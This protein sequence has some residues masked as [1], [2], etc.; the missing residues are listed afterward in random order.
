MMKE[1]RVKVWDIAVRIFHWS[2]VLFFVIAY[3]TGEDE[4]QLHNL[5]GYVVLGLIV[6]RIIWGFIG[7]RYARFWEF[8][9]SPKNTM[10]Y[11]RSLF[12]GNPKYY[13]GHNP[14]GGWMIMA[15]LVFLALTIWSGLELEASAGR[16]PLAVD[17]PL[18]QSVY[19]DDDR[20]EHEDEHA[21]GQQDRKPPKEID[22]VL[23]R[24]TLGTRFHTCPAQQLR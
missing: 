20:H 10:T 15:L 14:L 2:L 17:L 8:I 3:I 6:F 23:R 9:Y 18:V 7:T 13:V 5:A 4:S 1:E 11:A 16:G 12:S 21:D 24:G 19:A 22:G